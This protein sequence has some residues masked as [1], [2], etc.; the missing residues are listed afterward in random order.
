MVKISLT[1][2]LLLAL[3]FQVMAQ[4][5]VSKARWKTSE[6][7][8]DGNDREWTKPLNFFENNT[9]LLFAIC[10]DN[11]YLYFDFTCK[12]EMKMRKLMSAGWS[13]EL[14]SNEKNKKFKAT[15]TFPA[16]EMAGMGYR[17]DDNPFEKRESGNPFLAAY[18]SQLNTIAVKGFHSNQ[19]EIKL[20]DRNGID[21]AVGAD[22][23]QHLVYELAIPLNELMAENVCQLNELITLDVF[24]KGL[25]RPS[26]VK[27][28]SGRGGD[29]SGG[30]MEEMGG[31][32]QGGG[33]E[34]GRHGGGMRPDGGQGESSSFAGNSLFEIATFNQKF[35]LAKE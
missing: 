9:G 15:L 27:R 3:T 32:R 25:K 5:D 31:G 14:S 22:S 10:N 26:T 7:T 4:G 33:M 21:V 18:Q 17:R 19:N 24:V 8:I 29:P 16:I 2:I 30:D 6:I 11:H 20:S 1:L 34:G 23:A 12:E 13:V 35:T 28:Q